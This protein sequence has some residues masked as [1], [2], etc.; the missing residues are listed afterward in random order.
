MW[1]GSLRV[2]QLK[3]DSAVV[4]ALHV[5]SFDVILALEH[6]P[7]SSPEDVS[8]LNQSIFPSGFKFGRLAQGH[9]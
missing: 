6:D 9:G 1:D 4:C 3:Y 8:F 5:S 7:I 2:Q